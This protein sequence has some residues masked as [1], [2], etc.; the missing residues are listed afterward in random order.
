MSPVPPERRLQEASSSPYN[1]SLHHFKKRVNL[2]PFHYLTYPLKNNWSKISPLLDKYNHVTRTMAILLGGLGLIVMLDQH[3]WKLPRW[4][5]AKDGK[6]N[7]EP[8]FKHDNERYTVDELAEKKLMDML[9]E[10]KASEAGE[11][12]GEGTELPS[13]DD[14]EDQVEREGE[15]EFLEDAEEGV[16]DVIEEMEM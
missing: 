9:K 8:S 15:E 1:A 16:G 4:P 14:E 5:W 3:H 13:W 12:I 10:I 11:E 6:N 7:P 2:N